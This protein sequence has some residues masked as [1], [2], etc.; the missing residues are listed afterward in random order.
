M[1]AT[2]V[3]VK[4]AHHAKTR[5]ASV[6][7]ERERADL[8]RTLLV[9][10]VR[11]ARTLGP[12][13]VVSRSARMRRLATDEHATALVEQGHDLDA[14]V[15]QGLAWASRN[16]DTALVLPA[17]L[18]AVTGHDLVVLARALGN[19]ERAR[20]AVVACQREEGTNALLLRPPRAIL[21][22]FGPGSFA[23]HVAAAEA[24]GVDVVVHRSSAF[25]D[26]DLPED[27]RRHGPAD[28]R[29]AGATVVDGA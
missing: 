8:V 25:V 28:V 12:V 2:V 29:D 18:V 5:L 27:W 23:R 19:D 26:L 11:V 22:A 10:T 7:S 6:L 15:R 24:A 3:P 16:A 21:P 1:I 14:A 20:V 4:P 17:D 9:R 13:A